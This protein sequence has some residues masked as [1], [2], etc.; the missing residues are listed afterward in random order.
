MAM[1][2]PPPDVRASGSRARITGPASIG[3]A[4]RRAAARL[5]PAG[6]VCYDGMIRERHPDPG[7]STEGRPIMPLTLRPRAAAGPMIDG[8]ALRPEN[9]A[10]PAVEASRVRLPVGNATAEVGELFEVGGDGGDGRLIFEGDFRRVRGLVSRM[11][12]GRV[13]VRGDAGPALGSGMV[14][15]S[16]EVEGSVG[17]WA[18][19]EMRGGLLRVRGRAGDHLG[20]ALPGSRVGMRDGVILVGGD[21]GADV[22]LAM[23]RGLI[24][25]GGR[26]GDGLG[27]G[28]VAGSIFALGPVG[29]HPGAG[30][31]RGTIALLGLDDPDAPGLL[32]G[33]EPSGTFRPYFLTIYLR[34]LRD[35]GFAVPEAAFAATVRRYNGDRVEG[36]RG[37][38][39]L[40]SIR[41]PEAPR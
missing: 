8:D 32:P 38:V 27:R 20:A 6:Q 40:A 36:G 3:E 10:G 5:R 11:T 2:A 16:I 7:I 18:G 23:R 34:E 24:A 26:S 39:L 9:L 30:M 19:A 25:V 12:S 31:K 17:P 4:A 21:A 14:G 41:S 28:L 37:E 33:F 29:R 35:R 15:G 13:E 1:I 22:G